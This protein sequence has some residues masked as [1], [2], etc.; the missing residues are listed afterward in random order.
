M[1]VNNILTDNELP[2]STCA[3]NAQV[4][5]EGGGDRFIERKVTYYNL[6]LTEQSVCSYFE[7]TATDGKKYIVK[8]II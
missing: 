2:I 5:K 6:E 4:Q 7:H 8:F 3:E 1:M